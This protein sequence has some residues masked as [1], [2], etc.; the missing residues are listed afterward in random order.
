[1][2]LLLGKIEVEKLELLGLRSI[3]QSLQGVI[4]S[5]E[6]RTERQDDR[7]EEL[8]VMVKGGSALDGDEVDA[9]LSAEVDPTSS[10][11]VDASLSHDG[12]T[13]HEHGDASCHAGTSCHVEQNPP[14]GSEGVRLSP[15]QHQREG[16]P[17]MTEDIEVVVLIAR[18]MCVAVESRQCE[19]PEDQ[20]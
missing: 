11:E 12:V 4:Q 18:I 20:S 3:V 19:S 15:L 5:L 6:L 7:I 10:G 14:S 9:S 8:V 16:S 2:T 1:M 13:T 17:Q